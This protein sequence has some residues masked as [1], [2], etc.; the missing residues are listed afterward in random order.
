M[1]RKNKLDVPPYYKLI[2]QPKLSQKQKDITTETCDII[3]N[4]DR[5]PGSSLAY[6]KFG[7]KNS[8]NNA[9]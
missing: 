3:Q 1:V 8:Q 5:R 6:R 7:Y 4:Q 9:L 2:T